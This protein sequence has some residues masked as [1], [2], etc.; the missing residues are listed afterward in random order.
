M[1]TLLV[2]TGGRCVGCL[3][4]CGLYQLFHISCCVTSL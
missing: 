4:L 1:A 3:C 2:M